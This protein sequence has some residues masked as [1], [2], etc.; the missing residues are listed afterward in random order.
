MRRTRGLFGSRVS[1]PSVCVMC[2]GSGGYADRLLTHPNVLVV[3]MVVVLL[4]LLAGEGVLAQLSPQAAPG[5]RRAGWNATLP[6]VCVQYPPRE[7]IAS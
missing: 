4:L 1:G 2:Y 3:V 5:E 6:V 7:T